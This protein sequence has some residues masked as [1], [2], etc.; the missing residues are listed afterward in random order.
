VNV[1]NLNSG[2]QEILLIDEVVDFF[3]ELKK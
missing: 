2:K 3:K 1:K